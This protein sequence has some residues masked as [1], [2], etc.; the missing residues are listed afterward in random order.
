[1]PGRTRQDVV[2]LR[3]YDG[4]RVVIGPEDARKILMDCAFAG[5][6]TINPGNMRAHT[7]DMQRGLFRPGSQIVFAQMPD[8]SLILVN[9]YHRLHAVVE[10]DTVVEFQIMIE[11]V[12]DHEGVRDLYCSLDTN[13]LKRSDS[14]ISRAADLGAG[15]G[16]KQNI[17][18]RALGAVAIIASG[19]RV[20]KIVD[21]PA[22][23]VTAYGRKDAV[24]E[25][26]AEL[27]I[28][29][30]IMGKATKAMKLRLHTQSMMAIAL[31]TLRYQPAEAIEFWTGV[32]ENDGL[33]KGDPRKALVG[34]LL[35]G[36][37]RRRPE[38]GMLHASVAWNAW[39]EGRPLRILRIYAKT[40]CR[41]IGTPFG[42]TGEPDPTQDDDA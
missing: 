28:Y 35:E 29:A 5:Q 26:A 21:R 10:A 18:A 9:G 41:P 17:A 24:K 14:Q 7:L 2:G 25:W 27:R 32:A 6:R 15:I 19:L 4:A 1:M 38:S 30:D 12:A 22:D 37:H 11:P 20:L 36:T 40:R 42:L 34:V 39:I 8:D 33:R 3:I 13:I 31:V 23:V 16:V